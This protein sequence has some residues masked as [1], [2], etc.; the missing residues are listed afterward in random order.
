MADEDQQDAAAK[1]E[2]PRLFGRKKRRTAPAP[3]PQDATPEPEPEPEPTPMPEPEPEP[4]PEPD[5]EPE[6]T[7]EPEPEPAAAEPADVETTQVIE[8]DEPTEV[9]LEPAAPAAPAEDEPTQVV[10]PDPAPQV[11][12]APPL[13]ADEVED[14]PAAEAEPAAV[15]PE[16]Q[17]AKAEEPQAPQPAKEPRAP[18]EPLSGRAATALTGVVVGLVLV[19][20]TYGALQGCEAVQGTSSCGRAGFPLLALVFVA[21]IAVG[22]LLLGRFAVPDPTSTSFLA[23]GMTSVVALLFLIDVLDHWS[24]ILVIPLVSVAT[25]LLSHWVTATFIEPTPD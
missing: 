10:Q 16:T 17:A 4:E 13:F 6:P 5:P 18:R 7:P 15:V 11:E 19:G 9:A 22:A 1:L 23:T 21:G 8:T 24:M 14:E 20:G 25:H 2:P 12:S 3:V